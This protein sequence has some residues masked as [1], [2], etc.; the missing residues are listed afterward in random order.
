M[1]SKKF[2]FHACSLLIHPHN[3]LSKDILTEFSFI[4]DKR[5]DSSL[6]LCL[7]EFM[8]RVCAQAAEAGAATE[9]LELGFRAGLGPRRVAALPLSLVVSSQSFLLLKD[10]FMLCAIGLYVCNVYYVHA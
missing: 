8:L 3:Y 7:P 1:L 4:K 6:C 5:Y 10:L 9:L 2:S